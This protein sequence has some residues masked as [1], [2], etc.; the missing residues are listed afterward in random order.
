MNRRLD[1][2]DL[3]RIPPVY[4]P[5]STT[6]TDYDGDEI[7]GDFE[8]SGSPAA[9]S[10][11]NSYESGLRRKFAG[12]PDDEA[13]YLHNDHLGTLRT[14]TDDYYA[15]AADVERTQVS[16]VRAWSGVRWMGTG[17]SRAAIIGAGVSVVRTG[18]SAVARRV[19]T[20]SAGADVDGTKIPVAR[21]G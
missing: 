8:I 5:L 15:A 7:Y 4:T 9:V 14:S 1:P 12:T 18:R 13:R 2:A 11:T 21:A 16:V 3:L 10:N 20:R 17:A 19:R 6:W